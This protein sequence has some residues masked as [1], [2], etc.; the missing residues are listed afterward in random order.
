MLQC[1]ITKEG[2]LAEVPVQDIEKG[3]WISL[4]DPSREELRLVADVARLPSLDMLKAALDDEERAHIEIDEGNILIVINIPFMEDE[5]SF[6]TLPL[7]IVITADYF[8]TISLR[9]N[10]VISFF[11]SDNNK[12]FQTF[13]KTPFMFQ[14]LFRSAKLFLRYLRYINRHTE[15]IE[16]E[17]MRS[18]KNKGLIQM[19]EI[20]KS[21]VY[22]TTALKSNSMVIERVSRLLRNKNN[23]YIQPLT[24]E[25]EDL[26]EDIIIENKQALEMVEIHSNIL[27]SMMDA[28]ASIINNNMNNVMKFL[29]VMTILLA[30]PTMLASFWGMNV[31]VPFQKSHYGFFFVM[32]FASLL[33]I[34]TGIVLW[35]KN[36][37]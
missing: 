4:T 17:L 13:R 11:N 31:H 34:V 1:F 33:T 10:K 23:T 14:I 12:F 2:T 8:I 37:F 26:L 29:A 25:D 5:N 30:I 16:E 20:E 7:G 6:D 19:M 32:M 3:C 24:E 18:L 36:K 22:F 15:H 21:L 27:S 9:E 28:F 35:K